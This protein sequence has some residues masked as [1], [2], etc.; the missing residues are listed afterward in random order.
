MK[1]NKKKQIYKKIEQN[2]IQYK[3]LGLAYAKGNIFLLRPPNQH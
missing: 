1:L 2:C 3:L